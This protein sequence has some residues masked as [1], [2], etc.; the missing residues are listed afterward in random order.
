MRLTV[1]LRND[2]PMVCAGDCPSYRSVRVDLT[3]EQCAAI[4][5]RHTHST[6]G[7]DYHEEISRCFIEADKAQKRD[8]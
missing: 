3:P 7:N 4:E 1:I 8:T 2:G 5:L 6:G